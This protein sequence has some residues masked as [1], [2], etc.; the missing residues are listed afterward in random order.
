MDKLYLDFLEVGFL[1]WHKTFPLCHT[2]S[3]IDE[4]W[5]SKNWSA[6][7]IMQSYSQMCEKFRMKCKC[8]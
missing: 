2:D 3:I 5:E 1:G 4:A 6:E 8:D 7:G